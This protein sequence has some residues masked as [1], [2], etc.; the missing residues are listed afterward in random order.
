MPG[1]PRL[2]LHFDINETILLGDAAGG[3]TYD[4]C[5][6]KVLAKV[7]YVRPVQPAEQKGGRWAAWEW[8]DGSPLDPELRGDAPPPPLLPDL[9][10]EPAGCQKFY[11]V[12]ELKKPFAKK[13]IE[14]GSPGAIYR[15]EY[16][17]L[18]DA[19][20]W[21]ASVPVD[22]RAARGASEP[23]A[24]PS[25]RYPPPPLPRVASRHNRDGFGSRPQAYAL[26][27]G[28]IRASL[29][30]STRC[31]RCA[32]QA[33]HSRSYFAPLAPIYLVCRPRSMPSPRASTRFILVRQ[34]TPTMDGP[35]LT[36]LE[37]PFT[38]WQ[39][40]PAQSSTYQRSACGAAA[41]APPMAPSRCGRTAMPTTMISP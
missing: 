11:N 16:E 12:K 24:P 38:S 29:P 5:L 4:E 18:R 3:D 36:C 1:R 25:A 8:H 33:G 9:F 14:N 2:C 39:A 41:I 6:N 31:S 22:S 7:A 40:S 28:T 23:A 26:Q 37:H 35:L 17:R 32:S 13:F 30:F 27:R 20:K 10:A 15:S 21:P 19:L 34:T